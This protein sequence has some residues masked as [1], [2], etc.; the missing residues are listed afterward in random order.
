MKDIVLGRTLKLE[1]NNM[2]YE[3]KL[4]FVKEHLGEKIEFSDTCY[5]E[6][7]TSILGGLHAS[8]RFMD[9]NGV[10][11][12]YCRPI[13]KKKL[14]PWTLET[15]E[16][17]QVR[18]KELGHKVWMNYAKDLCFCHDIKGNF[19]HISYELIMDTWETVDGRP[20]GT[21]VME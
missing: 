6:N 5:D 18:H 2:T 8:G 3:E 20:C 11:W 12:Y 7:E 10:E 16:S 1:I 9:Y 15:A 17:V 19:A 14:I 4:A 13:P 21:E